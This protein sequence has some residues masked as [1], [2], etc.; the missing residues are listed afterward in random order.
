MSLNE[1]I[2][3]TKKTIEITDQFQQAFDILEKTNI[4]LFITGKAGTGKSTFLEFFRKKTAKN[5]AVVAPTGVSA[6]NVRG[7]TI[8]SFFGFKPAFMAPD[9]MKAK[10]SPK[11]IFQELE[12][13]IIDEISMVRADV[14]EAIEAF[15]RLNGPHKGMAFG[16][17]QI[18]VI[19]DLFQLPPIVSYSE[20]EVFF[21]YFKSP[22]F[23]DTEAFAKA[24]FKTIE[25]DHMFRQKD[26]EFI[27]ALNELRAG[28]NHQNIIDFF[29]QRHVPDPSHHHKSHVTMTTTNKV[30]EQINQSKLNALSTSIYKYYAT[31]SGKFD[32]NES[33]L[34]APEILELKENAQIMFV[35]NDQ[36]KRWV[37]GTIGVIKSLQP[38][39]IEVAIVKNGRPRTYKIEKER[40]DS[41][42]YEFDEES[43]T[44]KENVIGTYTQYPLILAWAI[45]IHKSQGKTLDST[46]IDLGS[47][48]FASGQLY[49]ALSRCR[50]FENITLKNPIT[51][52][53]IKNDHRVNEFY[54]K[55][56]A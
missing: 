37:N 35:R 26:R 38:T 24:D 33:R 3:A 36:N 9:S 4:N 49:V 8:H 42:A 28:S 5:V 50:E 29:N 56:L 43:Q 54:N 14:F 21:N 46:I 10:L 52:R 13:L 39:S 19:G 53:D 51:H 22:F 48:A 16:G 45:T 12:I 44:V 2:K 55:V 27:A 1:A 34:P 18:C 41:I 11:K 20:E 7:Q 31:I 17:V 15:L 47:G 6:L 23:F 32:S 40:W 30:A 25:L